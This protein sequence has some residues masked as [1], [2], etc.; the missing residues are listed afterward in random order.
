MLCFLSCTIRAQLKDSVVEA[1]EKVITLSEVVVSKNVN[2]P[3]FISRVQGDTSFYKSFRNLRI[4]GFTALNDIRMLSKRGG[5]I[6]SLNSTTRQIR[7]DSCRRMEVLSEQVTGDM[8]DKEGQL[9]YYTADMYASLFFTKG[10][11][12]GETNIVGNTSRNLS[13]KSGM[14]KRR[15]QLK[16]LFFDPGKRIPGIPLLSGKTELFDADII[17]Y[18]DMR[19]DYD[20]RNN[21]NC[22]VFTQKVK[23]GKEDR[24]LIDEMKTWFSDPG[25]EVLARNYA[26]SYDAGLFDCRVEMQ[27]EMGS[28]GDL[29]VPNLIR[30]TGNWKVPFKR[31]EHGLFTA[32]L[33]DFSR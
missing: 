19:I 27:V 5:L 21:K 23:P 1:G 25:M 28:F 13:G 14:D 33:S 7:T 2:V 12:C 24:V 18:Y 11:V 4:L 32:T 17:S 30:Y 8:Y 29:S 10:Q 20:T 22:F 3:Y 6:A 31:R 26:I 16:M 9:N 15:E